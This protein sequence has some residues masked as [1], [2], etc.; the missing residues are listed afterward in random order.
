MFPCP[1]SGAR[2]CAGDVAGERRPDFYRHYWGTWDDY[3]LEPVEILDAGQYR[4]LVV[5][6]ERGIGRVS[7]A[8]FESRWAVLYTMR[9]HKIVRIEHFSERAE[10]LEAARLSE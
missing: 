3:V 7:R 2:Y 9:K 4:V 6:N 1:A 8:P 5:Q 10:A